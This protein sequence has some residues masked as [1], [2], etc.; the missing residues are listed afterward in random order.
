MQI[1][2]TQEQENFNKPPLF[3][4]MQR[5]KF[6]DFPK[7]LL[8]LARNL[9]NPTNQIG[10][11][12]LCGYFR[13]ARRFFLPQDFYERDI[14]VVANILNCSVCEFITHA[15]KKVSRIRHQQIIVEYYRFQSFNKISKAMIK[16]EIDAMS[17][18]YLKPKLIFDRC[19][20]ILI[21]K[22]ITLPESG[23]IC[24]LI[25]QSLQ[26][27]KQAL[28]SRMSDQLAPETSVLLD[29]LFTRDY[30]E[31]SYRLTLLKRLS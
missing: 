8:D 13:A 15:Y 27:H 25:R 4:H 5:K 2:T 6:F 19:S 9:R 28:M 31:Q 29:S 23:T 22:R 24:E 3:D 10:F 12:L 26:S 18:Y 21:Q 7:K 30:G 17:S 16:H 14:A 1:L 11:L 20:D